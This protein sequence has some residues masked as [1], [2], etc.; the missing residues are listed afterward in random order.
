MNEMRSN[1][2][3]NIQLAASLLLQSESLSEL[4][5][6][7]DGE[8]GDFGEVVHFNGLIGSGWSAGGLNWHRSVDGIDAADR[9]VDA[10]FLGVLDRSSGGPHAFILCNES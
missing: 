1:V 6:V 8:G 9:L 10:G 3:C 4:G 7:F 2:H 5:Q